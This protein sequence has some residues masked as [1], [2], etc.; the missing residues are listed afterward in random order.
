VEVTEAQE[1]RAEHQEQRT[2]VV[3]V[4]AVVEPL[5]MLETGVQESLL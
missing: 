1:T 3:A 5:G 4:V 2:P